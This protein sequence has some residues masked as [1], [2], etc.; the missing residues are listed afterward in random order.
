MFYFLGLAVITFRAKLSFAQTDGGLVNCDG[1]DVP[2]DFNKFVELINKVLK[3][4]LFDFTMPL[5][6]ILFVY[7]GYLLMTSGGDTTK[8]KQAKKIFTNVLIGFAIALTAYLMV[9]LFLDIVGFKDQT[10]LIGN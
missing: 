2:C 3:M 4:V 10:G 7:A 9:K 1:V 6:V 5:T 8:V